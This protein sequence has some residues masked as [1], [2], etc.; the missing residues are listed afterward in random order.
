MKQLLPFLLLL[1]FFFRAEAQQ[2]YVPCLYDIAV[3][4]RDAEFPGYKDH[5]DEVFRSAKSRAANSRGDQEVYTIPVIVHVV[6]KN[7][8]EDIPLEQIEGQIEV[9]NQCFR[10][11]NPDTVNTRALFHPVVADA[12]IEFVLADVIRVE[13]QA[14]FQ[15]TLFGGLP[16]HVKVSA[17]GGS[18]AVDPESYMNIWVCAIKPISI[19]GLESPVLGYAYPP[20]DLPNWPAGA[21]APQL[22]LEGVVVDYRAFGDNLTYTVAG[23]NLP[24]RGRTTVHEVGHYLGLRHISGD[25]QGAILGIPDCNADDG[26]EDTPNQGLQSQFNCNPNQNTCNDGPGDLPDMIENYMDYSAET[27]QNSF[28]KGQADIM[29]A[30]LEGPRAGIV[31]PNVVSTA[32]AALELTRLYPNP[33][34]GTVHWNIPSELGAFHTLLFDMQGQLLRSLPSQQGQLSLDIT[35]LPAGIFFL[36]IRFDNGRSAVRKVVKQ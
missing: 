24:I 32:E 27:C 22:A 23:M 7:P 15:P 16:D 20:A 25:G 4:Q 11:Q 13:T 33:T 2:P 36:H 10:R 21:N 14:E 8:V 29:R 34:Q 6:W 30:V 31:L 28:T 3:D 12:G 26:V 18:D 19:F 1:S 5:V 9:L 17:D 35:D